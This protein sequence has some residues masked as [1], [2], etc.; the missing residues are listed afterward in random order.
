MRN[1]TGEFPMRYGGSF[2]VTRIILQNGFLRNA[3]RSYY[4]ATWRQEENNAILFKES[5]IFYREFEYYSSIY[6]FICQLCMYMQLWH[7]CQCR[8][9]LRVVRFQRDALL[10]SSDELEIPYAT[11]PPRQRLTTLN[12]FTAMQT[13]RYLS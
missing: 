13:S 9:S 2:T 6:R 12:N 3:R 10:T 8:S 7:E 1:S 11:V 4:I 5:T